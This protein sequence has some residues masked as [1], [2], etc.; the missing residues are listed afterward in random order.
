M[1]IYIFLIL[2]SVGII[3][4]LWGEFQYNRGQIFGQYLG[5]LKLI[6]YL[7]QKKVLGIRENGATYHLNSDGSE[8]DMLWD[9]NNRY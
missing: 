9:K 1:E 2:I 6:N 5:A 4:Y 7:Y 3:V 8:A